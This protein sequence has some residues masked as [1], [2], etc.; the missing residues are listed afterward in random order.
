VKASEDGNQVGLPYL[1][2][3]HNSHFSSKFQRAFESI[4]SALSN[5]GSKEIEIKTKFV[6]FNYLNHSIFS[7]NFF[8]TIHLIF[9]EQN[10]PKSEPHEGFVEVSQPQDQNRKPYDSP[11]GQIGLDENSEDEKSE[12]LREHFWTQ[13][14][15][16]HDT[17]QRNHN[18][19]RDPQNQALLTY[20]IQSKVFDSKLKNGNNGDNSQVHHHMQNQEP[21]KLVPIEIPV[22]TTPSALFVINAPSLANGQFSIN[23]DAQDNR[24]HFADL[25]E[26]VRQEFEMNK[27]KENNREKDPSEL[28]FYPKQPVLSKPKIQAIEAK[29]SKDAIQVRITYDK[30]FDGIIYAKGYYEDPQC[31]FVEQRSGQMVFEFLLEVNRCGTSFVD[32]FA[33]RGESYLENTLIFQ[34]EPTFQEV[35]DLSRHLKCMWSG[36]FDKT[37]QT[38]VNV[39]V[40]DS[41]TI[42]YSGDSVESHMDIQY[43]HGPN[44]VPIQG[45]VRIG[46]DLTL[47]VSLVGSDAN[48]FDLHV[49]DCIAHDG[50]IRNSVQLT[51]ERGCIIKKKLLGQWQKRRNVKEGTVTTLSYMQAFRFPEKMEV[52]FECNIEIC[53]FEC[54]NS[55]QEYDEIE[56]RSDDNSEE[57]KKKRAKRTVSSST[58]TRNDTRIE[59]IRL[60]RGIRV[61]VPNDL[62]FIEA[63]NMS[64]SLKNE[65]ILDRN[66]TICVPV[67]N[68]T[69]SLFMILITL[70][71]LCVITSIL[72]LKY[73]ETKNFNKNSIGVL[74]DKFVN[75]IIGYKH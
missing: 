47:S 22:D 63:R 28:Q 36:V 68:F 38:S 57:E 8:L 50:D 62:D 15:L 52:Y 70:I 61:V 51:D 5:Q 75:D 26:E 32:D 7:Y 2:E 3:N 39:D 40:L 19:R 33:T 34:N 35:W 43:G 41:Q 17:N 18:L 12:R 74:N 55:C 65:L 46:D 59:P 23:K 16:K 49:K 11:N 30:P 29:C 42:T 64:R 6:I 27:N 9:R 13:M 73:F 66:N 21:L 48:N 31:H 72:C 45:F 37:V 71:I 54:R 24:Q 10:Y 1:T 4:G 56:I 67:T 58:S 14:F 53:K 60:L 69:M 44:A 25:P 20:E